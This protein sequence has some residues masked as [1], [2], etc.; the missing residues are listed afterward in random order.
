MVGGMV[1]GLSTA[2]VHAGSRRHRRR[3]RS[4]YKGRIRRESG[5][6]GNVASERDSTLQVHL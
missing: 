1:T 4:Q 2:P 6:Q 3:N 5:R